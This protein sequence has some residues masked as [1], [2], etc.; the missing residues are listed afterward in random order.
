[1]PKISILKFALCCFAEII[2]LLCLEQLVKI[3]E[4]KAAEEAADMS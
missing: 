1:M 2:H 3:Q 4:T